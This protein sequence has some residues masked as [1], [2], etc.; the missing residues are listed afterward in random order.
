MGQ[1]EATGSCRGHSSP[2]LMYPLNTIIGVT[3]R[4]PVISSSIRGEGC[5]A[6]VPRRLPSDGSK[7]LPQELPWN[8]LIHLTNKNIST[9]RVLHTASCCCVNDWHIVNSIATFRNVCLA[10]VIIWW[11]LWHPFVHLDFRDCH[12]LSRLPVLTLSQDGSCHS[13]EIGSHRSRTHALALNVYILMMF[14]FVFF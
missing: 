3:G 10:P 14:L 12:Y 2:G 11:S 1:Q 6:V 8:D 4:N 7:F 9:T 5:A 13:T